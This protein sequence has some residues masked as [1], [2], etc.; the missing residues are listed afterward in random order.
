[1]RPPATD[2]QSPGAGLARTCWNSPGFK[3]PG[4]CPHKHV[5]WLVRQRG[6]VLMTRH[7]TRGLSY[8]QQC[9]AATGPWVQQQARPVCR[10]SQ[11][12]LRST[13]PSVVVA[14]VSRPSP[15]AGT[16]GC[17]VSMYSVHGCGHGAGG[18]GPQHV[19][20]QAE[21]ARLPHQRR[22]PVT[23]DVTYTE[24]EPREKGTGIVNSCRKDIP[25]NALVN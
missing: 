11:P 1:M 15:V 12:T 20:P 4:P 18:Q 7:K 8:P 16:G 13:F 23:A 2:A 17:S 6:A 5:C 10:G 25:S 22:S 14:R 21:T 9:A 19:R 24:H 3:Y